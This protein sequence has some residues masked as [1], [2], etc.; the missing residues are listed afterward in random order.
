MIWTVTCCNT[1]GWPPPTMKSYFFFHQIYA[2]I[3]RCE[4]SSSVYLL[5][6]LPIQWRPRLCP[7]TGR[8]NLT[9]A[10]KRG[11]S[12]AWKR[13]AI[14]ASKW[15]HRCTAKPRN[16][17]SALVRPRNDSIV[18][19]GFVYS[20]ASGNRIPCD[21]SRDGPSS[22]LARHCW[23]SRRACPDP[24]SIAPRPTTTY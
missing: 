24:R 21:G 12:S 19:N 4:F 13:R 22:T 2:I 15:Q 23:A 8:W 20:P 11:I 10:N 14:P 3:L 16:F 9:V 18:F 5:S 6:R 17:K 1:D 7:C